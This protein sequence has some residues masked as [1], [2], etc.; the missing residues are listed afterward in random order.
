M[1]LHALG[2]V[3]EAWIAVSQMSRKPGGEQGGEGSL[4]HGHVFQG[5]PFT[6]TWKTQKQEDG[7]RGFKEV[8]PWPSRCARD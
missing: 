2:N 7:D 5:V 8:K 1:L 3:A 4:G 6:I